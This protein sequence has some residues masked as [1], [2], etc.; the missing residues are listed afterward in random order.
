MVYVDT[1]KTRI[2]LWIFV[3]MLLVLILGI[4]EKERWHHI[5]NNDV[6]LACCL[7]RLLE[8][9]LAELN[10]DVFFLLQRENP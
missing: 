7:H 2:I 3:Q 1:A 9:L 4:V 8:I 10:L 5:S 6:L